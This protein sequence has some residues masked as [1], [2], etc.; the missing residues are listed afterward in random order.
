MSRIPYIG[1]QVLYHT[2]QAL[3]KEK[4][5]KGYRRDLPAVFGCGPFFKDFIEF[6]TILL[7]FMSWFLGHKACGI[8]APQPGTKPIH[9]ASVSEVLTTG[10]PRKVPCSFDS[11]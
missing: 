11:K 4:D 5:R 8:Y 10:L 9:P 2:T 6:V 7:C 3:T 1:R